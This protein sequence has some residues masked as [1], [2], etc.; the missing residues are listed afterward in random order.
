M[1]ELVPLLMRIISPPLRPVRLLH[2]LRTSNPPLGDE[3]G[4]T[5]IGQ[6]E[7]SETG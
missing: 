2:R 6:C 4:L 7:Y 1:T 3:S 5:R